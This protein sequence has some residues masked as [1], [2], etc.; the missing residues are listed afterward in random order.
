MIQGMFL[1]LAVLTMNVRATQ[2]VFFG[3]VSAVSDGDTLWVRPETGGRPRQLRIDGID[4]PER[5]QTGGEASR[6]T[7]AAHVLDR[8]VEVTVRRYDDYGR[9]LAR[10]VVDKKDV[11]A[12]MVSSG[13]AWSYRWRSSPG[14]YSP[15]E[16]LARRAG[17]G[18][19]ASGGPELPRDFRK[20]HGPC[21]PP[22]PRKRHEK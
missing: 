20:R 14:P 3:K 22:T 13:H 5:C 21:H 9:A 11:G 10:L 12:Y 19:F 16:V 17:R 2:D 15:E 18:I 4:A 1:L 6:K 7:L 8:R